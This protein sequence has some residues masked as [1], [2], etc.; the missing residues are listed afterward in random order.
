MAR[1]GE[2]VEAPPPDPIVKA[3]VEESEKPKHIA[4]LNFGLLSGADMVRMS[5][6][7]VCNHALYQINT[8]IPTAYGC[9]DPRLGVSDKVRACV[10][11]R[12]GSSG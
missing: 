1:R 5:H 3:R 10:D 9:L 7:Q 8:R 6:L 4:Q 11:W 12:V 2:Y